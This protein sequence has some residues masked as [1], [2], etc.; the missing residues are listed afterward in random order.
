MMHADDCGFLLMKILTLASFILSG[1]NGEFG[2]QPRNSV[3]M[4]SVVFEISH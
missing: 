1:M 3:R 4:I 2:R